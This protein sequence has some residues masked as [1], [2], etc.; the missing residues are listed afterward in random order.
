MIRVV[1]PIVVFLVVLLDGSRATAQQQDPE[2]QSTPAAARK[3]I[4]S[5]TRRQLRDY[6]FDPFYKVVLKPD[7]TMKRG[8]IVSSPAGRFRFGIYQDGDLQL[9][10]SSDNKVIWR[11]GLNNTATCKMQGDG[12][13]LARSASNK[14]IW[15]TFSSKH[16]GAVL[17][18]DDRGIVSILYQNTL[19]WFAGLPRSRYFGPSSDNLVFPVRGAFYYPW[20]PETWSVN[21]KSVFYQP[22][23]G[24]Y[25]SGSAGA[26]AAHVDA[27]NYA[28]VDLAIASW[29]GRNEHL[30]R[31]RITSLMDK[32]LY[33]NLKWAIYYEKEY[34][35]DPSVVEI[36]RDLTYLK[37]WFAWHSAYGHV[38]GRPV[39]FVYNEGGCEVVARWKSASKGEWYVVLKVFAGH[40]EC[41]VQPDH[42]H[43]YAPAKAVSWQPEYSFTV[44]PGFWR[45]DEAKP[46]LPRLSQQNWRAN[47]LQMVSSNE[48]W[49]LITS[50][51]EWGEGTSVE[52]AREW[53][54]ISRYGRYLDTLHNIH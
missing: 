19:I 46:R 31:A 35:V 7:T 17:I 23:L 41:A 20:F 8:D 33:S 44:S 22:T 36:R 52:S 49:Q 28:H 51:N 37:K 43:Q 14:V 24:K 38:D 25:T 42:W 54:S 27:L 15:Q 4:R 2:S 48:D 12:N 30:D 11:A 3:L 32:S 53:A 34:S 45:A 16:P 13:M 1:L 18:L 21:G 6:R 29:W 5:P 47:V 50:F 9:R 10:R 39:I 26:Q 40:K